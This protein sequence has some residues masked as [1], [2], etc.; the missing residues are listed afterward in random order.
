MS[1]SYFIH[2]L[3]NLFNV[4]AISTVSLMSSDLYFSPQEDSKC[5]TD[6]SGKKHF[7]IFFFDESLYNKS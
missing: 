4:S 2:F 1:S 6:F 7:N 3:L 5:E